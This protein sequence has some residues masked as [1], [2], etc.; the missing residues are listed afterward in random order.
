MFDKGSGTDRT[1]AVDTRVSRRQYESPDL[2]CINFRRRRSCH[3]RKCGQFAFSKRETPRK[4]PMTPFDQLPAALQTRLKRLIDTA[5][6]RGAAGLLQASRMANCA[7]TSDVAASV[8]RFVGPMLRE[9]GVGR[10][11]LNAAFPEKSCS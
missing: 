10:A 11:N 7:W 2:D 1:I 4:L 9:H 5:A 8:M 6:G 3:A